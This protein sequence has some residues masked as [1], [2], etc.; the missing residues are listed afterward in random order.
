MATL[1]K[2]KTL[3]W[4]LL[5]SSLFSAAPASAVSFWE[6]AVHLQRA[7]YY[8]ANS[9]YHGMTAFFYSDFYDII[10][11][12][13]LYQSW[14]SAKYASD[15]AWQAYSL[16]PTGT[17]TKTYAYYTWYYLKNASTYL[18][19][20]YIDVNTA[21]SILQAR[22]NATNGQKYGGWGMQAAAG[23]Y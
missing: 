14:N 3:A 16:A 19:N 2:R 9:W 4:V 21:N 13:V 22:N 17:L 15:E 20:V 23:Q 7:N 6:A 1:L 18:Y 12:N 10:L 8:G 5:A 11:P